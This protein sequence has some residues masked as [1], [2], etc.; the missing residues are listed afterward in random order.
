MAKDPFD[1]MLQRYRGLLYTLSRRFSHRGLEFDDLLQE[2]CIGLWRAR[3]SL[4]A[5]SGPAQAAMVWKVARNTIIDCLRRT[6]D[7]EALP[8]GYDHPDDDRTLLA[9]LH[10]A[11]GRLDE[12][13]RTIVGMQLKGYSYEEIGEAVGMTEKNVSVR[14]VR[15][16]EKLRKE[17]VG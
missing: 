9:E 3:V 5:L 16:K 2:A 17:F 10:E 15:A 6:P 8:A 1:E 11:V 12:P 7:N 14:L 4:L 13:D